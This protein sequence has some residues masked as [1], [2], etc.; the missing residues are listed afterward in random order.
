MIS[1]FSVLFIIL[2][3]NVYAIILSIH[4]KEKLLKMV[5]VLFLSFT[6]F[7]YFILY[8]FSLA[9]SPENLF[10]LKNVVLVSLITIPVLSY[11]CIMILNKGGL[12]IF[13]KCFLVLTGV[14]F[15]F[16]IYIAPRGIINTDFGYKVLYNDGWQFIITLIQFCFSGYLI[17]VSLNYFKREKNF[18]L[19][20]TYFLFFLGYII[21]IIEGL[22][23]FY[24]NNLLPENIISEGIILIAIISCLKIKL[25]N[26]E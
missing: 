20:F 25:I 14:I 18:K 10:M 12:N 16:V 3:A 7:R 4:L 23:S 22:L 26:R 13:D 24:Q 17:Y 6:L 1:Y 8:L 5:V 9:Q 2:M 21:E 11:L 19:K 15:A